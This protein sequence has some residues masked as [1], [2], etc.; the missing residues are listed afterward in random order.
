M[1]LRSSL[2][3]AAIVADVV[4]VG[5]YNHDHVWRTAQ[6]PAPGETRLGTFDSGPGG[7]GFNQAVAAAR[8]G[9][10][11]A[12]VGA[13][14]TDAI[15]EGMV[16]LGTEEG[17]DL[18]LERHAEH[19][20]GTAAILV[21]A[22][23]QNMIV[24]G[25]G[26]NAELSAA[27][28]E[29]QASLI[30]TARVLVT[31]HEVNPEATRRALDLARASG[32]LTLHNPAPPLADEDGGLLDRIDILTPNESEFAHLLRRCAGLAADADTLAQL[33]DEQLHA[34][35]RRLGVPTVVLTL[36]ARG[37]FV[38]H[39]AEEA[40]GDATPFY[41]LAAEAVTPRDTT[42]AG[43]AFSGALAA[44]LCRL[45]AAP[46]RQAVRHANRTAGLAVE[47]PGAASAMPTRAAVQARFGSE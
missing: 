7:K 37:V 30:G 11:T 22:S 14:G 13:L 9:A 45:G 38:S 12:F 15:G 25:P 16:R 31:Q 28:V 19:A 4:V 39:D 41:R 26:A 23:G 33:S 17:L 27:H 32:T 5:S 1:R 2:M 46:F 18:R 40:R 8:Q 43:D 29:A 20:T 35:C 47:S 36:G 10:R 6:F 24:V 42:G 44:A 3:V 21:D 34:S